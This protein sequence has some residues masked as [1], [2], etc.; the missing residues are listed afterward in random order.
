LGSLNLLYYTL[1]YSHKK[2]VYAII[3]PKKD[4]MAEI[5]NKSRKKTRIVKVIIRKLTGS[6]KVIFWSIMTSQIKTKKLPSSA[7]FCCTCPQLNISLSEKGAF[8]HRHI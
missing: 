5:F 2:I 1:F 3:L 7:F 4:L 8:A 6:K